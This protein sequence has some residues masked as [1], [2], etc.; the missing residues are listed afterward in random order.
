MINGIIISLISTIIL[1]AVLSYIYK[2]F[3]KK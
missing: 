3:I 2:E 1:I